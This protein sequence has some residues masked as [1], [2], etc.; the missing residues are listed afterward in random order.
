MR[1]RSGLPEPARPPALA[2]ERGSGA[3]PDGERGRAEPVGI[4]PLSAV[5]AK[6]STPRSQSSGYVALAGGE[7]TN[8]TPGVK[9]WAGECPR[10]STWSAAA[11][12]G[13]VCHETSPHP[14]RGWLAFIALGFS[15]ALGA[16]GNQALFERLSSGDVSVDGENAQGLALLAEGG[17]GGFST[18]SLAE[19]C[20]PR[21]SDGGRAARAAVTRLRAVDGSSP[22]STPLSCRTDSPVPPRRR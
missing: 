10:P 17:A 6:R 12:L 20:G 4:P 11:P 7:F 5:A 14:R 21:R 22:R 15:L 3:H 16:L 13:P 2:P 9:C 8:W 18:Y 19:R 1:R